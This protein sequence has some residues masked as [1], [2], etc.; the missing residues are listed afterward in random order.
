MIRERCGRQQRQQKSW[1]SHL[2]RP[3][4]FANFD[5][6]AS[7]CNHKASVPN[8]QIC[9]GRLASSQPQLQHIALAP[10][11]WG[12]QRI[13]GSQFLL[14]CR[15][16]TLFAP[17]SP[18]VC[19]CSTAWRP[20]KVPISTGC[21]NTTCTIPKKLFASSSEPCPL[22]RIELESWPHS[23]AGFTVKGNEQ[24]CNVSCQFWLNDHRNSWE[25][26]KAFLPN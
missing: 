10:S 2:H 3:V 25:S 21:R 16:V 9:G 22:L 13:L 7:K 14:P 24:G 6:A 26:P 15:H 19:F 4:Y 17:L 8:I 11:D 5:L 12:E 1:A 20:P 23:E 18:F